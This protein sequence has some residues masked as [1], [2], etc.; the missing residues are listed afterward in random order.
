[1]GFTDFY[2]SEIY[3]LL[4]ENTHG[5]H[6]SAAAPAHRGSA[7][8]AGDG[9]GRTAAAGDAADHNTDAVAGARERARLTALNAAQQQ[10]IAWP[11]T[12]VLSFLPA[13]HVPLA[14]VPHAG[15]TVGEIIG[16]RVWRIDTQCRLRS[17]RMSNV[18]T[19]GEPMCGDVDGNHGVHAY[20]GL[21]ERV[22]QAAIA[23][24]TNATWAWMCMKNDDVMLP[25]MAIGTVALWGQVIEHEHGYRAEYALPRSIDQVSVCLLMAD[26]PLLT[27]LREK[28][29]LQS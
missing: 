6:R 1:M 4:R 22:H 21:T 14:R 10:Q 12:R 7:A 17:A 20:R 27:M 5:R 8:L 23:Y 18:W 29:G 19:P 28:Y 26:I 11:Q 15:V 24:G 16:H 3:R 9:A 2:T 25:A 13:D